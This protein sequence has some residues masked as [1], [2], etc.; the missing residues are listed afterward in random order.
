MQDMGIEDYLLAGAVIGIQGQ[1]L[2]R[3][4]CQACKVVDD[5]VNRDSIKELSN[6]IPEDATY[7]EVKGVQYVII[8]AT[9]DVR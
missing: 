6:Y 5:S 2:V 7:I 4:I 1:R 3:K 9:L 8:V